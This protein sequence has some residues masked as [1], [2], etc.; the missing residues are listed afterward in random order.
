MH[1]VR[2][3]KDIRIKIRT[4]NATYAQWNG[5]VK[6]KQIPLCKYHHDLY[7]NGQLNHADTREIARYT[8]K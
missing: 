3:A 6:R 1:H 5:A 4:G 7:H 8:G 2:E